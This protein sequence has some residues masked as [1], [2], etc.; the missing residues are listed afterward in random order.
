MF[1]RSLLIDAYGNRKNPPYSDDARLVD[2]D[3]GPRGSKWPWAV[4]LRR[5]LDVHCVNAGQTA[6]NQMTNFKLN[7]STAFYDRY[8]ANTLITDSLCLC[9]YTY[10]TNIFSV[11]HADA[12]RTVKNRHSSCSS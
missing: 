3:E 5:R 9:F 11:T 8:H 6:T 1:P 12:Q 10:K 4:R 7:L 2:N